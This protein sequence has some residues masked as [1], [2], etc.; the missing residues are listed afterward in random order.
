MKHLSTFFVAATLMACSPALAEPCPGGGVPGLNRVA[1]RLR[2][3]P[4]AA[5]QSAL[6]ACDGRAYE[7][8]SLLNAALDRIEKLERNQITNL[9]D[10]TDGKR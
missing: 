4:V 8:G 5:S 6:N 2:V 3:G 9:K 7:I 10:A 1:H